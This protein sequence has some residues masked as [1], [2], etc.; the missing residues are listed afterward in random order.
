MT[1]GETN[2]SLPNGPGRVTEEQ[3]RFA[4]DNLKQHG[5]VTVPWIVSAGVKA[6]M[7]REVLALA[8]RFGCR[9]ELT[10]P[11]THPAGLAVLARS[12]SRAS[13]PRSAGQ[14]LA[15]RLPACCARSRRVL[16]PNQ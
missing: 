1:V 10:C 2:R 4:H 12:S 16:D 3:I 9:R 14:E 15:G 11:E 8:K 5:V 7:A 6:G 13:H